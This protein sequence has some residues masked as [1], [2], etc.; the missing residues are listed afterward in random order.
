MEQRK[1]Q[2]TLVLKQDDLTRLNRDNE[3]LLGEYR[4]QVKVLHAHEARIQTL[5]GEI[6]GLQ[7]AEAKSVGITEQLQQQIAT[8]RLDAK[9]FNET[10]ARSSERELALKLQLASA[11]FENEQLRRALSEQAQ[12][13]E[14]NGETT[15]ASAS[16]GAGAKQ[17]K[18]RRS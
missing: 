17:P 6:Q 4:Q 7:L 14:S 13:E 1:L 9:A 5:T 2:E 10:A 15:D 18:T 11:Q 12:P 8:L 16:K 3:R